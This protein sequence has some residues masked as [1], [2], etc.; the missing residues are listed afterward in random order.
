M[1]DD[2]QLYVKTD[3]DEELSEALKNLKSP[4]FSSLVFFISLLFLVSLVF[5]AWHFHWV[6]PVTKYYIGLAIAAISVVS[7]FKIHKYYL[8]QRPYLVRGSV[9]HHASG[10]SDAVALRDKQLA[11]RGYITTK[12]AL[13]V[14]Q[15]MI[16]QHKIEV[17]K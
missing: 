16:N 2:Q 17:Y 15:A 9:V 3:V 7:L 10:K 5:S 14:M 8:L 11:E 1:S 6:D 4:F 13:A 12:T